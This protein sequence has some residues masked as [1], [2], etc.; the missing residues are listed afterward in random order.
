M[1]Q[2]DLPRYRCH[3]EVGAL[4]IKEVGPIIDGWAELTFSDANFDT[5]AERLSVDAEWMGKHSPM[6]GGYLVVY[7]DGYVSFSPAKAFEEGYQRI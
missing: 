2:E 4:K 7:V 3:K 1:R 6:A 5:W